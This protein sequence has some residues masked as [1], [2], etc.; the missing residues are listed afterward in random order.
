MSVCVLLTSTR[1]GSRGS[2]GSG[3]R[4]DSQGGTLL[5][6][7]WASKTMREKQT[8]KVP[9][10]SLRAQKEKE[11]AEVLEGNGTKTLS[12]KLNWQ[13][14]TT[15]MMIKLIMN[16]KLLLQSRCQCSS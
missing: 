10:Q 12:T 4:G 5:L 7:S 14:L 9:K 13:R 11:E 15:M 8:N 3:G 1:S 16:S 6:G 2:K